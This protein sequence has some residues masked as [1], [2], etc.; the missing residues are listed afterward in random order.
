MNS[1]M[2]SEWFRPAGVELTRIRPWEEDIAIPKDVKKQAKHLF[3]D[4][5]RSQEHYINRKWKNRHQGRRLTTILHKGRCWAETQRFVKQ[6][7]T[8][9]YCF[10]VS[11]TILI[12]WDDLQTFFH[13]TDSYLQRF[14]LLS[15]SNEIC[16]T[17]GHIHISINDPQEALSVKRFMANHPEAMYAFAHPCDSHHGIENEYKCNIKDHPSRWFDKNLYNWHEAISSKGGPIAFREEYET[18]EFRMLDIAQTWEMQ[19]EHMAFA[20]AFVK[21]ALSHKQKKILFLDEIET[22]TVDDHI[23]NF[24]KLI[25]LLKLPWNRYKWYTMNIKTRFRFIKEDEKKYGKKVNDDSEHEEFEEDDMPE[26]PNVVEYDSGVPEGDEPS[27]PVMDNS[28]I[29][30]PETPRET[31]ARINRRIREGN[32]SELNSDCDIYTLAA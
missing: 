7:D 19:E 24:E 18:V 20:Q 5:K 17:G 9:P 32:I 21:Y 14:G 8:D 2:L 26:M 25:K 15:F 12:K 10:E 28:D 23:A 6:F 11:S 27:I 30:N 29:V 4:D 1:P 3:P 13:N 16:G 31:L 22:R